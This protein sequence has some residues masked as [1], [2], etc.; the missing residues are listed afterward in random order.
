MFLTFQQIDDAILFFIHNNLQTAFLDFTMPLVSLL[1]NS[2]GVWI[3]IALALLIPKRTRL[4]GL[5]MGVALILCLLIGNLALKPL[6]ARIRPYDVYT[7]VSLLIPPLTDFSFPSGHTM[8]SFAA[9]AVIFMADR[10]CGAAA[11]AAASLIA[12]SRLYLFV[13][14][15]SDVFAGMVIGT[16]IAFAAIQIV[17]KS[18]EKLLKKHE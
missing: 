18:R 5:N 6:V 16:A 8:S 7:N 10:R 11:L 4:T 14:Y 12:F 15:P 17:Q 9:A 1:G 13:H 3:V 2:G